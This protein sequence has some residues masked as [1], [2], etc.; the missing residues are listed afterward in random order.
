M[1]FNGT[2]ALNYRASDQGSEVYTEANSNTGTVTIIVN[3]VNDAPVANDISSSVDEDWSGHTVAIV[4]TGG[5]DAAATDVEGDALTYYIV[6]PQAME[7]FIMMEGGQAGDALVAGDLL[8]SAFTIYNPNS[9]YHG[10]DTFTF[11]ANDGS[12]DSNTATVTITINAVNDDI[13][14]KNETNDEVAI[15][16]LI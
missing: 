7:I 14:F 9:N 2:I 10:T 3:P 13:S 1:N 16:Q 6:D 8:T 5:S 11:K 4:G 12:L 15:M